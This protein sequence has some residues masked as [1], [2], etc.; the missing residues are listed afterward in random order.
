MCSLLHWL[1]RGEEVGQRVR[2]GWRPWGLVAEVAMPRDVEGS[3]VGY[4]SL[5]GLPTQIAPKTAVVWGHLPLAPLP[6]PFTL[7]F[8]IHSHAIPQAQNLQALL[9]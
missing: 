5:N 7:G 4:A 6:W 1:L 8:A 9:L 3:C 2:A